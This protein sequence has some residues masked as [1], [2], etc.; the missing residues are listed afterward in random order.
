[1]KFMIVAAALMS[2]DP[3]VY[4]DQDAC[5]LAAEK[6]AGLSGYE[7]AICMPAPDHVDTE[8]AMQE[9]ILG[10]FQQQLESA[11]SQASD[12]L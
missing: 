11:Q 9:L 1:M 6:L 7:D 5:N 4:S 12:N 10:L 2:N 8:N 3:Y